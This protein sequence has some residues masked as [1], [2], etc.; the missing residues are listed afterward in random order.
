MIGERLA[1]SWL[2]YVITGF[3]ITSFGKC[4]GEFGAMGTGRDGSF[5]GRELD[6]VL[7]P[8]PGDGVTKLRFSD[9]SDRLLVSSWD[10]KLRLYDIASHTMKA[11]F[12]CQGP[13]LDGCFHDDGSGYS[14][15]ADSN[16]TRYDFNTGSETT[17]GSH[18]GP[19]CSLEY[20]PATG[21]VISG[22]WD[23][24]LRC[25]DARSSSLA[26]T[27]AQPGGVSCMSLLEHRLVVATE[28][29]HVLVYDVRKMSEAEQSTETHVRFQTRSVCCSPDG[30]G[31]AMGS[32][33][34]R[35]II[36]WFDPSE[37][38]AKKYVFKCHRK[39]EGGPKIFYPVNALA[40]HPLYGTL[41]TGGGDR[42]VNVWDVHSRK[43]LYQY[44]K[45]PNSISSLAFNRDGRLLAIASSSTF[46]ESDES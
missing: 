24:T 1:K 36:D 7:W 15:C 13:V 8:L 26:G 5:L 4:C 21:Q 17:L 29:R 14:A 27:Y 20:S 11:E 31:F 32:I 34:G 38:Q 12:Q 43:R 23:K 45:C 33:D 39:G 30:T 10:S 3:V 46:E 16:L 35:V 25:W 28:G 42:H 40:F 18:D 2:F 37:A 41:A 22:S 6:T 9:H 44:S 19:I